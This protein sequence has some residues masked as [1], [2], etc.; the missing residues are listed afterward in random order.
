MTKIAVLITGQLN[1]NSKLFF[2]KNFCRKVK[3]FD[4]FISSYEEDISY[5][6]M[7]K[8]K[9]IKYL[10][11][12]NYDLLKNKPI[13]LRGKI[14][15]NKDCLGIYQWYHLDKIISSNYNDLKKYDLIIKLRPDIYFK[16]IS[17][18]NKCEINNDAIYCYYD[19]LFYGTALHF[20]NVFSGFYKNIC[21]K[22]VYS[23]N[24][25]LEIN[26]EN[27]VKSDL[28]YPELLN[29]ALPKFVINKNINKTKKIIR[30][31]MQD[32]QEEVFDTKIF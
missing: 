3:D 2:K 17:F 4:L 29:L 1:R 27:L 25:Y 6:K 20:L 5:I 14:K 28:T 9:K 12:E 18:L 10:N 32:L 8:Q 19:L 30:N 13:N 23:Y 16:N 26:Y 21:N 7:I 31:N 24:K 22:Y 11:I 15:K